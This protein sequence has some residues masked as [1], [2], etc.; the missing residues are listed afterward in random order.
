MPIQALR[1]NP[2]EIRADPH[3]MAIKEKA[4]RRER[5]KSTK[6]RL[7]K[8]MTRKLPSSLFESS[9]FKVALVKVMKHF[10]GI[11]AL[12][13]GS[14]LYYVGLTRDLYG[15]MNGHLKD[16]HRHRWDTF[17]I[18][19][20]KNINYLKDIETL[21]LQIHPTNGNRQLGKVPSKYNLTQP[22]KAVL[23]QLKKEIDSI[24]KTL[25]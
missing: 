22:F 16:R 17:K 25:K 2:C 8:G 6:G 9:Y 15:R 13:K 12:Y 7:I 23:K 14:E 20:I 1:Y 3:S 24:E 5:R 11:Y 19:R 10:S 18:F 4:T 21:I